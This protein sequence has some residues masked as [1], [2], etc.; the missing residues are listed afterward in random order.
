[1]TDNIIEL[2][3]KNALIN[4]KQDLLKEDIIPEEILT[5]YY[6]NYQKQKDL[7]ENY[8][9]ITCNVNFGYNRNLK[10]LKRE[11]D[12]MIPCSKPQNYPNIKKAK[13]PWKNIYEIAF[14]I[15]ETKTVTTHIEKENNKQMKIKEAA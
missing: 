6:N 4:L 8:E 11:L 15:S 9:K 7:R 2:I 13:G 14:G 1:M 5:S 12:N 3:D 10:T